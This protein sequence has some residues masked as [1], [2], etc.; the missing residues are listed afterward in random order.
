MTKSEFIDSIDSYEELI[1]FCE[2]HGIS[3]G[4]ILDEDDYSRKM[5]QDITDGIRYETWESI[6]DYLNGCPDYSQTGYYRRNGRFDYDALYDTDLGY[7][8]DYV[9][10]EAVEAGIIEDDTGETEEERYARLQAEAD[11]AARKQ[12]EAEEQMCDKLADFLNEVA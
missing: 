11:E 1:E 6:R 5:D 10:N 2:E 3:C 9:A 8:L 12:R 7:D 4:E